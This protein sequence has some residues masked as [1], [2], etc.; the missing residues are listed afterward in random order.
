MKKSQ[1]I[2]FPEST[3][4]QTNHFVKIL[5]KKKIP[6]VSLPQ[7]ASASFQFL[8]VCRD[9][10]V[11]PFLVTGRDEEFGIQLPPESFTLQDVANAIGR[12]T[13]VR[14]IDVDTQ[15][16]IIKYT[17]GDYADYLTDPSPARKLKIL[18]MISLEFS[19][20][21]FSD[22][23]S[24]PNFVR[25]IDWVHTVWPLDAIADVGFCKVERY[26]LIGMAGSYTDFHIDFGGTSVWY[27]IV[28]GKKR[29]YLIPPTKN[30]L[31]AYEKWTCSARQATTFLGDLVDHCFYFDLTPGNT[32][33][34]P[35]GWIHSVYTP[36]ESIVFGG[37]FLNSYSILAQLQ[38]NAIEQRTK[39]SKAFTFPLFM[40]SH[41]YFL[42]QMISHFRAFVEVGC[43]AS[44]LWTDDDVIRHTVTSPFVLKQIPFL[45]LMMSRWVGAN[46][47]ALEGSDSSVPQL[48]AEWWSVL[49]EIATNF[50]LAGETTVL[51]FL[52]VMRSKTY[53]D[54]LFF[55]EEW[56]GAIYNAPAFEV[57]MKNLEILPFDAEEYNCWY[58]PA[59]P[60]IGRKRGKAESDDDDYG[61]AVEECAEDE[62]VDDEEASPVSSAKSSPTAK[63]S[64][65][66]R[67]SPRPLPKPASVKNEQP[68]ASLN[69]RSNKA[70]STPRSSLMQK[71]YGKK[72]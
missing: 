19:Q 30:N 31:L 63:A 13:P 22:D 51:A 62:E 39:V 21:P 34:I 68:K 53:S 44:V 55:D 5:K 36:E 43:D 35:S 66:E 12:Q 38:A 1:G 45:L 59:E 11:S 69:T 60:T 29:F 33:I 37:N 40:K 70:S 46:G 50:D 54:D 52:K 64:K 42:S 9:G 6:K 20:S 8:R 47:A 24:P 28:R 57:F 4:Y 41:W 25:K 49:E 48:I 71:L 56:I 3:T 14:L 10:F 27:H 61:E 32:L 16:E 26:C 23:V 72:K 7:I 58:E 67:S 15:S 2:H 18:N 17:I 65:L